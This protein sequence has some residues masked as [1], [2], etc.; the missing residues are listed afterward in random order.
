M[1]IN[2]KGYFM[3]YAKNDVFTDGKNIKT[4][5]SNKGLLNTFLF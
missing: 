5:D 4:I 3:N 2:I 1:K